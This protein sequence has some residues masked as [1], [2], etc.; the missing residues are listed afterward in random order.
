MNSR[1]IATL[2]DL[3]RNQWF[4]SVGVPDTKRAIVLSS[5]DEAI[6]SCSSLEWEN[7]CLE[8]VNQYCA[9]VIERSKERYARWNATV[10]ELKKVTEPFVHRKIESVVRKYQL[11]DLFEQTVRWDVLHVCMEA[12]YADVFP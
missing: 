12:E 5:W 6:A 8:A 7:L 11:P 10:N 2:N 9:R 3:D 4:V 1:T